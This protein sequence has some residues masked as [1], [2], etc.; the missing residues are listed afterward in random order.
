MWSNP[1][2]LTLSQLFE[3]APLAD[4]GVRLIWRGSGADQLHIVQRIR[5]ARSQL[6]AAECAEHF[7]PPVVS[8]D[9]LTMLLRPLAL[10]SIA[11]T[12]LQ[13]WLDSTLAQ[14][15]DTASETEQALT[16][17]FTPFSPNSEFAGDLHAIAEVAGLSPNAVLQRFCAGTYVVTHLGFRPGF[18]YML[19]LDPALRVPRRTTPRTSVPAGAVAIAENMVGIYPQPSPGGWNLLGTTSAVM[20]DANRANPA[21]LRA[22]QSVRFERID[23]GPCEPN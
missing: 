20:F 6:E 1:A 22:G 4:H 10:S 18:P 8:F 21:L 12:D 23:L 14:H 15:A 7:Y 3:L 9:A 5:S 17:P 11:F 13:Q 19:G 2:M 16:L